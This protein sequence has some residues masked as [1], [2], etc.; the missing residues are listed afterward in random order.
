MELEPAAAGENW[1][2]LG[3]G[4]RRK[5]GTGKQM[6]HAYQVP[7]QVGLVFPVPLQ[8]PVFCLITEDANDVEVLLKECEALQ[9]AGCG[10]LQGETN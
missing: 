1:R 8:P 2:P 9:H 7:F 5:L 3:N 6:T 4:G 10:N